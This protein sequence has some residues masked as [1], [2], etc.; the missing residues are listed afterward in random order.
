LK[1]DQR[2]IIAPDYIL[3]PSEVFAA[4]A[5]AIAE[6]TGSLSMFQFLNFCQHDPANLLQLPSWVPDWSTK[7]YINQFVWIGEGELQF[8]AAKGIRH[9]VT[10]LDPLK[11]NEFTVFGQV[12]DCISKLLKPYFSSRRDSLERR[13]E[14]PRF[15]SLSD[16]QITMLDKTAYSDEMDSL[17]KR[18]ITILSAG[19]LR[20]E[21]NSL[22]SRL[23]SHHPTAESVLRIYDDNTNDLSGLD[24]ICFLA[25]RLSQGKLFH[26][27]GG[28][29]GLVPSSALDGDCI[30]VLHGSIVP[31]VLRPLVDGTYN[32]VGQCYLENVMYGEAVTWG[33]DSADTLRLV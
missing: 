7:G 30:A 32:V 33:E 5:R 17:R 20:V 8:S 11:Y 27:R 19:R 31:V 26:S 29:L 16:E 15:F 9:R 1:N 23:C 10:Q 24:Y 4:A 22:P 18:I 2:V 14:R 13:R 6:G 28:R 3:S 21:G 25:G 12:I